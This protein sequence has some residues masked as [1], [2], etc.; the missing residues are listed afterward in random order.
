VTSESTQTEENLC[1]DFYLK[2]ATWYQA[3]WARKIFSDF[4]FLHSIIVV[5]VVKKH[6]ARS[7]PVKTEQKILIKCKHIFFTKVIQTPWTGLARLTS[8]GS[9]IQ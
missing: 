8:T 4:G 1:Q 7:Q 9:N 5:F 6:I 2:A 3:K